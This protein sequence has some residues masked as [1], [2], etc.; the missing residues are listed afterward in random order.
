MLRNLTRTLCL[1][2]AAGALASSVFAQTE[3]RIAP[4]SSKY[5]VSTNAGAVNLVSGQVGV[6]RE[7]GDSGHLFSG[8]S[9]EVG[10][11]VSTGRNGK[12]EILLNPGSYLR[13]GP[14]SAFEF[15]TTSLEDLQIKL[16]SGSAVLEVFA[17]EDFVVSVTT[18]KSSFRIIDSGVYRIDVDGMGVGKIQV[19][20]GKAELGDR[21]ASVVKS[22][23]EGL[24]A[25]GSASIKKFDRGD[26][27]E[28]DSWSKGRAKELAKLVAGLDRSNMRTSLMRSFLGR[29]WDLY[30]SFGLWIYDP[31]RRSHCFLPFGW[32]WGSPY[33]YGFG[34]NIYYYN[35]PPVVF[36]PPPSGVTPGSP[37]LTVKPGR[38]QGAPV[39]PPYTQVQGSSESTGSNIRTSKPGRG[40]GV[41]PSIA[42][43][44]IR[45]SS[46][47]IF[48]PPSSAPVSAPI[49]DA[50]PGRKP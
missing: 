17:T 2:V 18:P 6:V 32:G 7:V 19:E 4:A 14:L 44:P 41:N 23:R 43:D 9:L 24:V 26:R 13:L 5:V 21:N 31:F 50:K 40:V 49:L 47:T 12:A 28:L 16:H 30:G 37:V 45:S 20:K 46:S 42:S 33:G 27:D 10:D 8:D 3:G 22:G 36:T 38:Q 48:S 1:V 25:G 11:R 35:L 29:Q 15:K 34:Y 39:R